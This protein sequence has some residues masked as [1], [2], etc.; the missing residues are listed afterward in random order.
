[1]SLEEAASLANVHEVAF[2]L[3]EASNYLSLDTINACAFGNLKKL[4]L[5]ARAILWVT[6]I[7]EFLMPANY[8]MVQGLSRVLRTENLN[9]NFVTVALNIDGG[10]VSGH[11]QK[12]C[13]VFENMFREYGSSREPEYLEKEGM[14]HINRMIEAN[15]LNHEILNKTSQQ[16]QT[17]KFK[18]APPLQLDIDTPGLLDTLRFIEDTTI[19]EPLATGEI[20]VEMK[21][22]GVNFLDCLVALG[23]VEAK[24]LGSEGSGIVTRVGEKCR[25]KPGDRVSIMDLDLFKT[26]ART[27]DSNAITIADDV[28]FIKAAAVPTGFT[29]V[30]YGL[31]EVARIQKGE[32][33][34]IHAGAGA[35]GQVAIQLAMYLGAIVFVTVGSNEK[36]RLLIDT[37]GIPEDHVLYSRDLSFARGIKRL[38]E[39]RGV[40]VVLNSLAGEG[41]IA[42]WECV[43]PVRHFCTHFSHDG[44]TT[45][46]SMGASSKSAKRIY[47]LTPNYRCV[48]LR[49]MS[50]SAPSIWLSNPIIGTPS[51]NNLLRK[52]WPI[53]PRV[54]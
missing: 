47:T 39:G 33:I 5:N 19:P 35:T 29:T 11:V 21:A 6:P 4:L 7:D 13:K 24:T 30:Y 18:D 3:L 8:G 52:P 2:V 36:K 50:L 45:D 40:D 51:S 20:E 46:Y 31:C 10:C 12:I 9:I 23:R 53:L 17:Q 42:S 54:Y 27:R 1:M 43:A 22:I 44:L 37:Y 48:L 26:Y 14:L 38:T 34:L 16:L 49:Q 41:L 25:H 15:Y 28:S 32:T